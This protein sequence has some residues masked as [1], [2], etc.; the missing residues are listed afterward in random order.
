MEWRSVLLS[1]QYM[2]GEPHLLSSNLV[3]RL[4]WSKFTIPSHSYVQVVCVIAR[5][6]TLLRWCLHIHYWCGFSIIKIVCLHTAGYHNSISDGI[7]CS[8]LHASSLNMLS[9]TMFSVRKPLGAELLS[10]TTSVSQL[11]SKELWSKSNNACNSS[12]RIIFMLVSSF[13]NPWKLELTQVF[14]NAS[15]ISTLEI[16]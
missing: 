13:T 5:P 8:F 9:L 4:S 7:P 14:R 2:V 1:N 16:Y 10:D 3:V 6:R 15:R 11:S 12:S